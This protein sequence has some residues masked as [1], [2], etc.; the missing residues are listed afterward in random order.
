MCEK[1]PCHHTGGG[2]WEFHTLF[3]VHFDLADDGHLF[4]DMI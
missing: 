4:T 1:L 3:N 2:L